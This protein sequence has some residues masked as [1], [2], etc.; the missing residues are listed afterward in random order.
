MR[1]P[2]KQAPSWRHA[3]AIRT[4]VFHLASSRGLP[5]AWCTIVA[6]QAVTNF[7]LDG[8]CA[9]QALEDAKQ[10]IELATHSLPPVTRVSGADASTPA[11]QDSAPLSWSLIGYGALFV[12]L[13]VCSFAVAAHDPWWLSRMT[14]RLLG[15]SP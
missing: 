3:Q 1:Q 12:A 13:L 8:R 4:I 9:E 11:N 14:S 7:L 10:Q 15:S 5:D 2:A 6:Q